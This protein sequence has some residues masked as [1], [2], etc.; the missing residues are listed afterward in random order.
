MAKAKKDVYANRA[1]VEVTQ[2]AA[3]DISFQQLAFA[4][5]VFQGIALKLLRIEYHPN[6]GTLKQVDHDSKYLA[7]GITLRDDLTNLNPTNQSIISR[8]QWATPSD[9]A[10]PAIKQFP[11]TV[12]F[13]TL[14][15]EGLLI[16]ANP[17][18]AC[19]QSGGIDSVA[20]MRMILYFVFVQLSDR[21]A[22][23]LLQ[24]II[25]GNI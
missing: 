20:T 24:T 6:M 1:F 15:G 18:Y 4:V 25:P 19:V 17:I 2:A 11:V 14:P 7:A 16:P 8:V 9:V 22:I 21:E 12:D 13:T 23:E 5:G 10:D 3:N